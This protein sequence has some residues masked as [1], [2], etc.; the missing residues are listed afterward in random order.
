MNISGNSILSLHSA[1]LRIDSSNLGVDDW[2]ILQNEMV[3]LMMKTRLD[4]I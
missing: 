2:A 3:Q 1:I 4:T